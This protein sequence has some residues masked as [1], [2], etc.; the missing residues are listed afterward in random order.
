MN[1]DCAREKSCF[2]NRCIDPCSGT[3]GQNTQCRVVNH[4][5]SCYCLS[6][7]TGNPLHACVPVKRK[8]I[9]LFFIYVHFY[10]IFLSLYSII[11]LPFISY[12]AFPDN[13]DPCHPSPCGPYSKCRISN[14]HAVCTCLDMCIGSPPNCHPECIVSSDCRSD[15]ACINQK[16]QDPC[17][18]I[19]GINAKCQVVNHNPI[20]S[21][22]SDYT[23]DPFVRCYI[24][25]RKSFTFLIP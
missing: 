25:D 4:A 14:G 12:V 19:C 8:N 6:G 17:S 10:I 11:F 5:P 1:T 18:G 13:L 23:G 24:D 20:C 22:L 21:C 2:N 9:F 7:F 3:C 15:K 16:C